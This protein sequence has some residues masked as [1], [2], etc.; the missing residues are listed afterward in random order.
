MN[1]QALSVSE[2]ILLAEQI[3]D[4]VLADADKVEI[5]Q[6]HTQILDERLQQ[7]DSTQ[8]VGDSWS[9]VK[10]RILTK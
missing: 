4:S 1:L 5:S 8:Q 6:Q 9:N 2:K 10:A 3:W 7:L